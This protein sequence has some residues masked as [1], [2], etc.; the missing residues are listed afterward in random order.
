MGHYLIDFLLYG[1]SKLIRMDAR[2]LA[3]VLHELLVYQRQNPECELL[4]NLRV[5]EEDCALFFQE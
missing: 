4:R 5:E 1:G 2:L 3:P